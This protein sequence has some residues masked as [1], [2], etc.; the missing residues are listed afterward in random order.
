MKDLTDNKLKRIGN[1]VASNWGA[2]CESYE[3]NEEEKSVTFY[4]NECGDRFYTTLSFDE[5]KEYNY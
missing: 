3:V 5:L 1:N 2:Y 4:C